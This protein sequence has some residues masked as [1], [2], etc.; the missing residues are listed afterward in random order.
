[1]KI[2]VVKSEQLESNTIITFETLIGE[3]KALWKSDHT[4]IINQRYDVEFN[5]NKPIEDLEY[6]FKPN[7]PNASISNED[8]F[9]QLLG[10]V[11]SIDFDQM[12]IFRLS[13]DCL[14]MIE[15]DSDCI[16]EGEWLFVTVEI[17]DFDAY[18]F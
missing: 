9:I 4:P 10:F 1:M 14:I 8:E 13:I 17:N 11:E 15:S 2:K 7:N 12:I 16:K 18:P 5:I 6:D 3:G